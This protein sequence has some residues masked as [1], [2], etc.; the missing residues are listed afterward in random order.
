MKQ[1]LIAIL[2]LL[3]AA[4]TAW[5]DCTADADAKKLAGAARASFLKKCEADAKA[6]SAASS[7]QAQ[8]DEKKLKGAA[9]GSFIKKCE[10][11]ADKA[12][13]PAKEEKTAKETKPA[14]E[15]KTK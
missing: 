4:S 3:F 7:C 15:G 9:R 12:A 6:P 13:K 11:D 1:M 14:K 5:A 8:A 10:A 2:S